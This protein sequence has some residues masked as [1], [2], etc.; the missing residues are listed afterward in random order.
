MAEEDK[1]AAA[2]GTTAG[3][4]VEAG[5][6]VASAGRSPVVAAVGTGPVVAAVEEESNVDVAAVVVA[7]DM[8][9]WGPL[10]AQAQGAG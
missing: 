5:I 8:V 2:V 10:V 7:M 6:V 3:S 4:W 1:P 9:H